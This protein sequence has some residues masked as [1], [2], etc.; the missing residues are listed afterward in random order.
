MCVVSMISDDWNNRRAPVYQ[1]I[2]VPGPSQAEF[3]ALKKELEELKKLLVAAKVYDDNTGQP[4]C[5]KEEKIEL[6]RRLAEI[7][8]VDFSDVFPDPAN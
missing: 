6:L 3:D 8:G 2:I 5:E 4:D 7:V 1:P